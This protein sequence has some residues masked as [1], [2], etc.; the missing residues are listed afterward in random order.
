MY[1]SNYR[2][3]RDP[4]AGYKQSLA[5]LEQAKT[6]V[7]GMVTKSSIMLGCGESDQQ[8]LQTLKGKALVNVLVAPAV[9]YTIVEKLKGKTYLANVSADIFIVWGTL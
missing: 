2:L 7:P 4:R 8:V 6:S 3:V 5:V 9:M 1:F